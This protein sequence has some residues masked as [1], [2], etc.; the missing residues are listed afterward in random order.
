MI[1]ENGDYAISAAARAAVARGTLQ[2]KLFGQLQLQVFHTHPETAQTQGAFWSRNRWPLWASLMLAECNA[3]IF[4]SL[5]WWWE[6]PPHPFGSP[7]AASRTLHCV[8]APCLPLL[9]HW[10]THH[11]AQ[12]PDIETSSIEDFWLFLRCICSGF[13]AQFSARKV[14]NHSRSSLDLNSE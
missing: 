8:R 6:C 1:L 2:E 7:E 14:T 3:G 13:E 4:S 9:T 11:L 12:R 5:P 10:R